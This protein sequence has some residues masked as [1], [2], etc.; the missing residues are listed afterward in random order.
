MAEF[1]PELGD[2][3]SLNSTLERNIVKKVAKKNSCYKCRY[4]EVTWDEAAPHGCNYFN[5]KGKYLPSLQLKKIT[6]AKVC[7]AFELRV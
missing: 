4:Y 5:F 1:N 6:G 3:R 7:I 2:N